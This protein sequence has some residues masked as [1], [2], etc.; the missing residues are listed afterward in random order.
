M[1]ALAL[2][3]GAKSNNGL[4]RLGNGSDS[5]ATKPVT[6]LPTHPEE[7]CLK[8]SVSPGLLPGRPDTQKLCFLS[9]V[10]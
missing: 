5:P 4:S 10:S 2:A 7:L 9:T 1:K 3:A 8:A 6:A